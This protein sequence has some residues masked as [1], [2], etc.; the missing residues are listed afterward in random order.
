MAHFN[1]SPET[2]G[3]EED[4]FEQ[5][6]EL[7]IWI[8]QDTP[9]LVPQTLKPLLDK[10]IELKTLTSTLP[11]WDPRKEIYKA[12]AAAHKWL[13]VTCF[14][15]LGYKNARFGRIEAHQSVTAYSRECL[16]RAKEAAEGGGRRVYQGTI[17][18]YLYRGKCADLT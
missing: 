16:L 4:G 2:V 3:R 6:P 1:I 5:V 18:S 15:Y 7:N 14:G 9:G 10:R 17:F 13:L 12:R 11:G 8:D